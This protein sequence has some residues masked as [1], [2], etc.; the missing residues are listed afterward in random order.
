MSEPQPPSVSKR[1]YRAGSG[2]LV[3]LIALLVAAGLL[4]IATVVGWRATQAPFPGFFTEPTLVITEMTDPAWRGQEGP[5][6]FPQQVVA[7]DGQPLQTPTAL[8]SALSAH[9]VGDEV[10][11]TVMDPHSRQRSEATVRLTRLP[12]S[13]LLNFYLLPV[14]LG[15]GILAIG[16]W[17]FRSASWEE[18]TPIFVVFC[19]VLSLIS[20]LF[21]DLLTTHL[22]WW[23]WVFSLPLGGSVALHLALTCPERVGPLRRARWLPILAYLP[24]VAIGLVAVAATT[25]WDTPTAYFDP[26]FWGMAWAGLGALGV[27]ASML[28]RRFLSPSPVVRSQ[29]RTVLWGTLLGFGPYAVWVLTTRSLSIPFSPLLILPWTILFPL[30]IAY[31]L[32]RHRTLDIDWIVRRVVTRILI[33]AG[34]V[35]LYL[36]L[37]VVGRALYPSLSPLHP[38]LLILFGLLVALGVQ[39]VR[40]GLERVVDRLVLG[41]RMPP[42]Q[43]FRAF[44]QEVATAR[45]DEA[46]ME[47]IGRVLEQALA[48]R[49]GLLYLMDE[50]AGW[51]IPRTVTGTPPAT[52]RFRPDRP[53]ARWMARDAR[54]IYLSPEGELPEELEPE[55]ERL[56]QLGPAFFVPLPGQ[57]WLTLGPTRARRFRAAD[58]RFLETLAPQIVAA[59]ERVRL[60][61]DLERRIEEM[62]VLRLI[63]QSVTYS[64][65]VDDLLELVYAQTGRLLDVSNFYIALYDTETRT[66][67]FA[68]YVEEGERKYPDDVWSDTEGLSGVIVRTGRAIVTDDYLAEC[69]RRGVQPGGRPGKAWM[70]MPLI[71]RDRVLGVINVSSFDPDVVYTEEQAHIFRAIAD[72]TAAILDKARL[73][74]L[75]ARRTRQLEALNEVGSVITSSLDLDV[76]LDL[77]MQKAI[78]LLQAEAGSLLLVDEDTG[79]LVFHVVTGPRKAELEGTRLPMGTGIVGRVARTASPIIV[80]DAQR[81][82]RWYSGLDAGSGFVTRSVICVPMIARGRVIGVIELLNRKDG[83]PFNAEDR[84]LLTAFASHAAIAIEN[85]RLFTMT[86]QA[87]AARVEELSMMQRIDRELNATLDYHRVMEITLDWAVRMTG[88]DVGIVA[89]V[90]ETEEG[91]RG[92]R[93]LAG[94]GYP[95]ELVSTYAEKP[96]PVDRGL[97]GR[98]VQT[99]KAEL[100]EDV[101][102][103]P[104]YEPVVEGMA[105]Q[106][107]VPIRREA[108]IIGVIALESSER[109]RFDQG[110]LEFVTRLA[111]HAAI[112]IEN[113]RLFEAVQAANN[114]K[115]EFVS[116]VSHELKQ[117]MTSIKGYADLLFKGT[118]GELNEMQRSFLEVIRSNVARMDALVQDLLDIS[119]IEAGRL[120]LEIRP[121]KIEEAVEEAVRLVRRQVEAKKQVLEVQIP[122]P[123][124]LV[125]ADRNRLIQ[126]LTN[127][128][129][130]AYKYTP[131]GGRIRV[132]AELED[133]R[134]V[135]CSVSDTGIGMTP[136]EQERLFTKYFRS[137][138]PA[139]RSVPGTGLGLVIT[140][141]LVELQGGEIWVE[142]EPGKGSTFTFTVPVAPSAGA[143]EEA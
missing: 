29:A 22:I 28:V 18:G 23:G 115:T 35:G 1:R 123:L 136:E 3:G 56:A 97:I 74:Q 79:D 116:F 63:A 30:S 61:A 103:D 41:R 108:Q 92:L 42:E 14:L 31:A 95:E 33:A 141:S 62:E 126:V 50:R 38:L 51:Y 5:L 91:Q 142:S 137:Q 78:E 106:L 72:Q 9:Q 117:P 6:R 99:G 71:A 34:I 65:Q 19:A 93:L 49:Y 58:V 8:A 13:T 139:V 96:W 44:A 77:I 2:R 102:A 26:W 101:R 53:L 89:V 43:A 90:V 111:D 10:R 45:S 109:G 87:L 143:D 131:E 85:A 16:V 52:V 11:L 132:A 64:V 80:D 82:R 138:N 57:G 127:L 69:E 40:A 66:L 54:P 105:T 68:F 84:H 15:W 59:L 94:Q 104:D 7:L 98:V 134:F 55:R 4:L 32:L 130:N 12:T 17:V 135:R 113:A 21:F 124:P 37:V 118:A 125:T 20:G 75:M 88:A 120:K 83:N 24:G 122:A 140:K 48:P 100:V 39:P 36:L 73:Y 81:D 114:A 76:V 67:R 112:A 47:A 25:R 133:G 86:D 27:F 128:L 110:A 119:R 107:T 46:V 129:S 70:G 60:V 121:V